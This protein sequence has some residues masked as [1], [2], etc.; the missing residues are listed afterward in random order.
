[1]ESQD[2]DTHFVYVHKI[3]GICPEEI[4]RHFGYFP[5]SHRKVSVN[6]KSAR[7]TREDGGLFLVQLGEGAL[8]RRIQKAIKTCGHQADED[9]DHPKQLIVALGGNQ[10]K[11]D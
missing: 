1:M 4:C 10:H 9:K 11:A 8:I 6:T 5:H 7:E 2:S 3:Q